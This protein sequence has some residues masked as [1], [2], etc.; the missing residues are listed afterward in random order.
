MSY[1][2]A[3]TVKQLRKALSRCPDNSEAIVVLRPEMSDPNDGYFVKKGTVP[4]FAESTPIS[5]DQFV[6]EIGEGFLY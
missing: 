6:I 2:T 3:L 4:H 1:Q 5:S